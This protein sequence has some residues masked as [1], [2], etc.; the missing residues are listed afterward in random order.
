MENIKDLLTQLSPS[1]LLTEEEAM[2]LFGEMS[3]T[4]AW[5]KPNMKSLDVS[6][7]EPGTEPE[8]NIY[9]YSPSEQVEAAYKLGT[10]AITINGTKY[11][12]NETAQLTIG[13]CAQVCS[14]LL[15]KLLDRDNPEYCDCN[16]AAKLYNFGLTHLGK[17]T[18]ILV[19]GGQVMSVFSDKYK[20]L[21]QEEIFTS[22][23][24]Q[25]R[26]RFPNAKNIETVYDHRE[27]VML[28]ELCDT[29]NKIFDGYRKAWLS[30]GL[31][32]DELREARFFVRIA[33]GDTGY[34]TFSALPIIMAGSS[35]EGW[36][37]LLSPSKAKH[38]GKVDTTVVDTLIADMFAG[39]EESIN[40]LAKMMQTPLK[41]PQKIYKKIVKDLR[42]ESNCKKLMQALDE[43][44][45]FLC[46]INGANT[47]VTAYGL[48]NAIF[49]IRYF[50]E[51]ANLSPAVQVKI[52][53][54]L[55]RLPNLDW[56]EL[57]K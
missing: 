22:A 16:A 49:E 46:N 14:R 24:A 27:T 53:D 8:Y 23:I 50:K 34:S 30:A 41:N 29:Q 56:D 57:N 31:R 33:S 3:R 12:M 19:R 32:E 4:D 17:D 10:F 38:I 13:Q 21:P 6:Y 26:D 43:S 51:F 42:L 15:S 28:F 36:K 9:P 45:D 20:V 52:N 35:R 2:E 44:V 55:S 18:L 48:Y 54:N 39:A 40:K 11:L 7:I 1:A 25:I 47:V 37:P 5:L